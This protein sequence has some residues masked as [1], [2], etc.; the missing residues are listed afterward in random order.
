MKGKSMKGKSRKSRHGGGGSYIKEFKHLTAFPTDIPNNVKKIMLKYNNIPEIPGNIIKNFTKLEYLSL[1]GNKLTTLPPEIGYLKN[2]EVLDLN[3]NELT[4]I[5]PEIGKLTKLRLL[6]LKKN[7][8][9]SIPPEIEKLPNLEVLELDNN[10]LTSIPPEIGKLAR[11]RR[12][13]LYNNNLTSI[14]PEIS[15]L[16]D[17]W[18]LRLDSNDITSI[19]PEIEKLTNLSLFDVHDNLLETL[20][21]ELLKLKEI[22]DKKNDDVRLS[23]NPYR[24]L[25][26]EMQVKLDKKLGNYKRPM[27]TEQWKSEMNTQKFAR[28]DKNN[29]NPLIR[30][31][32]SNDAEFKI[33]SFLPLKQQEEIMKAREPPT[34]KVER[35]E[36]P[37]DDDELANKT[38][39]INLGGG[40]RRTRR[41]SGRK[42]RKNH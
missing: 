41:K 33:F 2:L 36:L 25:T 7:K 17:L 10:E 18:Y 26:K 42:S 28:Q 34:K 15:N 3:I 27:P 31:G 12:L 4:S 37:L 38:R 30:S 22:T 35:E 40:K 8:L 6:N 29:T 14:P 11:L 21:D 39:N 19:P 16:R 20:P 23:S 13:S 5:P 32:L 9:T 1:E 24:Y